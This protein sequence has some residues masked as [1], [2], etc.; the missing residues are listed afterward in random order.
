MNLLTVYRATLA[1]HIIA[2][3]IGLA[4][5]WTPAIAKKGGTLHRRAGRIFYFATCGVAGTGVVIAL[6]LLAAPLA[7]HPAAIVTLGLRSKRRSPRGSG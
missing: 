4:A 3:F 1:L 6:L 7:V 5:F 2:G